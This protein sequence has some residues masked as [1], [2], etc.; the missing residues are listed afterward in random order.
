M[1]LWS[2][3]KDLGWTQKESAKMPESKSKT[4][5]RLIYF[6]PS[7]NTNFLMQ[8]IAW[9][10]QNI[11]SLKKHEFYNEFQLVVRTNNIS[12]VL[13]STAPEI[14]KECLDISMAL[15]SFVFVF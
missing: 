2:R 6:N 1:G 7:Q 12:L 13:L 14:E 15:Q 3:S 5:V 8:V 4:G 11:R 10:Q 9:F